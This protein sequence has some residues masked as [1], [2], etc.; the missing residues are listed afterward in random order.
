[1]KINSRYLIYKSG[2]ISNTK[3]EN[4]RFPGIPDISWKLIL[5]P[6][7]FLCLKLYQNIHISFSKQSWLLNTF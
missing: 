3:T 5:N 7:S 1:M 6:S 2:K 4:Y